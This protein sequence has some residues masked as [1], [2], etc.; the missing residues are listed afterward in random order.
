MDYNF[1]DEHNRTIP[2]DIPFGRKQNTKN[3]DV[4][5]ALVSVG[6][7]IAALIAFFIV[8]NSLFPNQEQNVGGAVMKGQSETE[9]RSET[10]VAEDSRGTVSYSQMTYERPNLSEILDLI[11]NVEDSCGTAEYAE[12]TSMIDAVNSA[13]WTFDTMYNLAN[14]KSCIDTTDEF[15]YNECLFFSENYPILNQK[16]DEM[17]YALAESPLADELDESYYNAAVLAGYTGE[18]DYSDELVDLYQNESDLIYQYQAL[19]SDPQITIDGENLGLYD[20]LSSV[21]SSEDYYSA[22]EQ[23]YNEYNPKAAEVYIELVKTRREIAEYLGYDSYIDYAYA[24]FSRDYTPD[25]VKDYIHDVCLG[26][27]PLYKKLMENGE[28]DLSYYPGYLSEDDNFASLKESCAAMGVDIQKIFEYM[29]KY[30]LYDITASNL[31]LNNSFQTYLEDWNA[32]FIMLYSLNTESDYTSF[33]HEF[34]HFID[35]YI[36]YNSNSPID[37]SEACSQSMEYLAA[38]YAPETL[39]DVLYLKML[40]AVELY[41][42]QGAYN[43]FEEAVYELSDS[44]LTADNINRIAG[45]IFTEYGVITDD[46]SSY[47]AKAWIDVNHFFSNPFYIVSYIVANDSAYQICMAELE[48]PGS[49]VQ[50]FLQLAD[51]DWAK[52]YLE[53][54]AD[55]GLDA[56]LSKERAAEIISSL[57]AYFSK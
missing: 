37:V 14:L 1:N 52:S 53:N 25:D 10:D 18:S 12:L 49:G 19:I 35:A 21:Y 44:E 13:Y 51:R 2:N 7:F 30:G 41:A 32:P 57:N 34:G 15:Y 6:I 27:V 11:D 5:T 9:D 36:N 42:V 3:K 8:F 24:A 38:V 56:S 50:T 54:V 29:E 45:E 17:M 33:A 31:K 28:M 26:A 55:I 20:Y 16:V 46:T 47:G 22:V 43:A 39:S 23:Y 48:S 40:D 4:R